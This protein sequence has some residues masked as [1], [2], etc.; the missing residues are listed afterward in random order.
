MSRRGEVF[1]RRRRKGTCALPCLGWRGG[2]GQ[3]PGSLRLSHTQTFQGEA[4][5]E[6]K[7]RSLSWGQVEEKRTRDYNR[8][9]ADPQ[10]DVDSCGPSLNGRK[11]Q[12]TGER[13]GG[14]GDTP[15]APPRSQSVLKWGH[16]AISGNVLVVTTGLGRGPSWRLADRGQGRCSTPHNTQPLSEKSYPAQCQQGRSAETAPS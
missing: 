14:E 2:S 15:V 1:P 13:K 10:R 8:G 11:P 4:F 12:D 5:L 3:T 7:K 16:P 9:N 6:K